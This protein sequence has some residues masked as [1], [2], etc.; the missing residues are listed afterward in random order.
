MEDGAINI[1]A[2]V[3]FFEMVDYD[4]KLQ[5]REFMDMLTV[6][7]EDYSEKSD[8]KNRHLSPIRNNFDIRLLKEKLFP[9]GLWE[10]DLNLFLTTIPEDKR[11]CYGYA[12][13]RFERYNHVFG[14]RV[15]RQKDPEMYIH[16]AS[17]TPFIRYGYVYSRNPME[18]Q[19]SDEN[20]LWLM[21]MV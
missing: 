11:K 9:C 13:K 17:K 4:Y 19:V 20:E 21:R 1:D 12:F 14:L 16:P 2:I 3:Y 10:S 8:F 6:Y 18:I 15:D 7:S 5:V